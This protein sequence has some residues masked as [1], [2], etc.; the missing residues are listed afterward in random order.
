MFLRVF[1]VAVDMS[2]HP[3][4]EFCD[5]LSFVSDFVPVRATGRGSPFGAPEGP[6]RVS[7]L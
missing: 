7:A 4:S 5:V 2:C 1:L 3:Q 6:E